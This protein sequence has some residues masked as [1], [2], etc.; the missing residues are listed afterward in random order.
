MKNVT[1]FT[2]LPETILG[3]T[4]NSAEEFFEYTMMVDIF[5]ENNNLNIVNGCA[6]SNFEDKSMNDKY[7]SRLKKKS[8]VLIISPVH[9]ANSN[10]LDL[11]I[12][13][14]VTFRVIK[15]DYLMKPKLLKKIWLEE[16]KTTKIP[17]AVENLFK[18]ELLTAEGKVSSI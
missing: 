11:F 10:I 8:T 13:K 9:V 17:L 15:G 1:F 6:I 3:R 5:A 18:T 2:L 12:S 4:R 7:F 16:A 14:D